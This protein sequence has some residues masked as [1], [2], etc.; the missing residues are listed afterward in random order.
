MCYNPRPG[1]DADAA[2]VPVVTQA[3]VAHYFGRRGVFANQAFPYLNA[4]YFDGT[5]P[6]PLVL[7]GLTPHGACLGATRTHGDAPIITLHPALLGSRELTTP[8][9]ID[10]RWLGPA[11]VCDVLLHEC[12]H[13]A[14]R[15]HHG[16]SSGATSHNS[17]EWLLR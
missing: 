17:P 1:T 5:L 4:T 3:V 9:G 14:V 10:A 16:G 6:W 15:L 2:V 7:W 11:L 12:L 8:W 13:L